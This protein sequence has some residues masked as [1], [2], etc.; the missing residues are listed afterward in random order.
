M[1]KALEMLQNTHNGFLRGRVGEQL[2]YCEN[3]STE[4]QEVE[5]AQYRLYLTDSGRTLGY[6]AVVTHTH[7]MPEPQRRHELPFT[8]WAFASQRLAAKEFAYDNAK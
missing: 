3:I 7:D 8:N 5:V 4:H 6:S 1:T 2:M